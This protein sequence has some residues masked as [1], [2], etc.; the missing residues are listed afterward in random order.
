MELNKIKGNTYYIDSPTNIGIYAFKNKFCLLID[1]GLNNSAAKKFDEVLKSNNL[2]PK[3]IINTHAH[4]DHCGGNLYFKEN[5]PGTLVYT[6]DKE[7][8]YME[9]PEILSI[10]SAS[11]SPIKK[12]SQNAKPLEVDFTLE[13]GANKINDEK[14]EII[15]LG[16]HSHEH[17]GVITPEKICFLGD[18]IF[19][20]DTLDKYAFPF[21]FDI[22]ETIN[23]LNKIKNIDADYFVISHGKEI[24]N[25]EEIT[26]LADRNLENINTH[27]NTILELL[28]QP[29][30]R[31]DILENIIVLNDIPV[32]MRKYMINLS[33]V[34]AFISYLYDNDLI[35]CSLE[36][37]K[38]YY[39]A[40]QQK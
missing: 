15:Q 9:N 8:V 17:I 37:G 33:A 20:A 31:E 21:L 23:T 22:G 25:K 4:R 26:I 14:F 27:I 34:S 32:N 29:Y 10:I 38:L 40:T 35:D 11:S 19:S 16:G 39:F 13:Y 3:Y 28:E 1:S 12:L 5:Y 30:T 24:L 7:R 18:S 6:S 36:D 2:H